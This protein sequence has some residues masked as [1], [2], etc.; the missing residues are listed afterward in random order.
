MEDVKFVIKTLLVTIVVIFVLQIRVGTNTIEAS[1]HAWIQNSAIT[2]MLRGVADG[3]I[4]VTLDFYHWL[5]SEAASIDSKHMSYWPFSSMET[6]SPQGSRRQH[7]PARDDGSMTTVYREA[8]ER[9]HSLVKSLQ[10][11]HQGKS[12]VG[13]DG[14]A[15][16]SHFRW[17][18]GAS[19]S[20]HSIGRSK[21][22][23]PEDVSSGD[24]AEIE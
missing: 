17:S 11:D 3:G 8:G 7:S 13:K 18:S 10:L 23:L 1:T 9:E 5:R 14:G 4:K 24:S 6:N 12:E 2:E 19:R 16:K 15:A 22:D 20:N 21:G